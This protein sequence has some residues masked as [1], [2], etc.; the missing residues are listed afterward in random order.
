MMICPETA[1]R[2]KQFWTIIV[3]ARGHSSWIIHPGEAPRAPT[4]TTSVER[5][6]THVGYMACCAELCRVSADSIFGSG[7]DGRHRIKWIEPVSVSELACACPLFQRHA[8]GFLQSSPLGCRC[9]IRGSG[10]LF[11]IFFLDSCFKNAFLHEYIS[12]EYNIFVIIS[13]LLNAA[14]HSDLLHI[15][16]G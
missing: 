8:R 15:R 14:V 6:D 4:Y 9:K 5:E 1:A 11:H 13:S 16:S 7:S 2:T 3:P 10:R 12:D